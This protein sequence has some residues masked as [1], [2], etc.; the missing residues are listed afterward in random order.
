[1]STSV[2]PLFT[3]WE[4]FVVSQAEDDTISQNNEVDKMLLLL[5]FYCK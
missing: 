2:S 5:H 4:S 3:C 1:M